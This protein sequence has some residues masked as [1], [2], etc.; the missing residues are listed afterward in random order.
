MKSLIL[1]ISILILIPSDI[2]TQNSQNFCVKVSKKD[3]CSGKYSY[4]CY[5]QKCSVDKVSCDQFMTMGF[6][7]TSFFT[8]LSAQ[9]NSL[10]KYNKFNNQIKQC[11]PIKYEWQPKNVCLKKMNCYSFTFYAVFFNKNFRECRCLGENSYSCGSRFCTSDKHGCEH[12]KKKIIQ[13]KEKLD[14]IEKC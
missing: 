7:L 8:S 6:Y 5:S 2:S 3:K 11:P 4:S 12:F 9:Q 13:H 10:K 1:F 14:Q